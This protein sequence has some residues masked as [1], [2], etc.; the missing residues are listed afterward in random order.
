MFPLPVTLLCFACTAADRCDP[1]GVDAGTGAAIIDGQEWHTTDVL[2]SWAG[3]SVQVTTADADGWRLTVVA[4]ASDPSLTDVLATDAT[5]R[6]PIGS[7]S[8]I[9][10][11]PSGS[12]GSY[13][14]REEGDGDLLLTRAGDLL[15]VCFDATAYADDDTSVQLT[16]GRLAATC[17]ADCG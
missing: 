2:W 7:G 8:F 12:T 16:D 15:S 11:Y 17:A 4:S 10:A 13:A 1:D 6:I 14:A 5:A 9:A 3:D